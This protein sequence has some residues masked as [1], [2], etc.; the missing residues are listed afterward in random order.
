MYPLNPISDR[1]EDENTPSLDISNRVSVTSRKRSPLYYFAKTA[2]SEVADCGR[3]RLDLQW[4]LL[5]FEKW[6][7]QYRSGR[8][9]K[10]SK[11]D[12]WLFIRCIN[13][14]SS[15][16]KRMLW[17]KLRMLQYIDWD[18][19][20]D[21]TLDPKGFLCLEDE[22]K[23]ITKAWAKLRSWLLK[24]YGHFEFFRVLEVQ[25]SGR[26]HLHILITGILHI[27]HKDLS[28]IWH[29][30][31]GGWVWIRSISNV[32]A[33]WYVIKYVNKSLQDDNR[34]YAALLFASNKRMFSMS[35][36]LVAMLCIRRRIKEGGW[37]YEGTV[38]ATVVREFCI[39]ENIP[40]GD[41][42]KIKATNA[43]YYKHPLL[44]DVWGSNSLVYI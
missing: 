28:A 44:F 37:T 33:V 6:M 15:H 25:K 23:F 41:V 27:S 26:P 20:L 9:V 39:D 13:R 11:G 19:K 29:K 22:F 18:L 36:N 8:Y 35:Q 1:V 32:N 7:E 12:E 14:F 42:I 2:L 38:H 21:L 10:L 30:Y 17:K 3:E 43:M 31:G 24:R 4:I 34:A 40:F 16:Y 5:H